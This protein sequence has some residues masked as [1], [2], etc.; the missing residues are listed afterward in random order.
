M[1]IHY[2]EK[3]EIDAQLNLIVLN[4]EEASLIL[5]LTPVLV[6]GEL[7][8][9]FNGAIIS[10]RRPSWYEIMVIDDHFSGYMHSM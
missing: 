5:I 1:I 10:K 2:N 9:I 6:P 7:D 8:K 3:L 4:Y